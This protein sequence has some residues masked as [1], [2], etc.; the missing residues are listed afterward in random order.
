MI[1]VGPSIIS[2]L[3]KHIPEN[4]FEDFLNQTSTHPLE[5]EAPRWGYRCNFKQSHKH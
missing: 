5:S 1:V 4:G 2:Y 3:E